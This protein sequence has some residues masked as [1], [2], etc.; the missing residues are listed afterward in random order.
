MVE[1]QGAHGITSWW[2]ANISLFYSTGW[3]N[4][5]DGWCRIFGTVKSI[6]PKKISL[7]VVANMKFSRFCFLNLK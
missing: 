4:M 2:A 5:L 7:E 3:Q 1:P 6:T